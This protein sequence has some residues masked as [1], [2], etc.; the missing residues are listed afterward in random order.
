MFLC[1]ARFREIPS[2]IAFFGDRG[3]IFHDPP[4]KSWYLKLMANHRFLAHSSYRDVLSHEL[5]RRQSSNSRYSLRSF[6]KKLNI[7]APALSEILSGKRGLSCNRAICIAQ[8]LEMNEIETEYFVALVES[9]HA[10][11]K[12]LK[13]LAQEK[14]Q[15]IRELRESPLDKDQFKSISEWYH[16]AILE[17]SRI[18]G[19]RSC[20]VW[21][22]EKLGISISSTRE[23]VKRLLR[24]GL[25]K[26]LGQQLVPSSD[27]M[28]AAISEVPSAAIRKFH[29]DL[30]KKAHEA[31]ENQN[32]N[33][34]HFSSLI[35]AIDGTDE[36]QIKEAK[37][38]VSEFNRRFNKLMTCNKNQTKLY[39]FS[40]QLYS[41]ETS[42]V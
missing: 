23:A 20:P 25:L 34:R 31:V 29:C 1:S 4:Y 37:K 41:L 13:A 2:T 12:K 6:A 40:T 27:D 36:N 28:I 14:V 30:L 3:W 11:S 24:L 5:A 17:L 26:Q 22:A 35:F 39:C 16:L 38:L 7:P 10:R 8:I 19:F 18:H 21:I 33:E 15:S 42:K 9:A 32:V